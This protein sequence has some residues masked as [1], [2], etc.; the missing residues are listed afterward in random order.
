MSSLEFR[1]DYTVNFSHIDNRGITRPSAI[2]DF[3]Q[4]AATVHANISGLS[5]SE[6][7]KS[8]NA[9]WLLCRLKYYLSRPLTPYE[10]VTVATW[11]RGLSGALWYRDFSFFVNGEQI[12]NAV[13]AWAVVNAETHRLLRPSALINTEKYVDPNRSNG[14]ILDKLHVEAKAAIAEHHVSYSDLDINNHLNNVKVV[15]I[16]SDAIEMNKQDSRFVSV[17]QVN[18]ISETAYG[19]NLQLF[20]GQS[21]EPNILVTAEADSKTKFEANIQFSEY[22]HK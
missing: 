10:T 20:R 6:L 16:I 3:M 19:S 14:E 9:I 2:A 17:L 4:D 12:G 1:Q 5:R 13:T 18:Y 22:V 11:H 7:V 8:A 21:S 15:D